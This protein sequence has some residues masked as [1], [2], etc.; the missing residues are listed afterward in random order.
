LPTWEHVLESVANWLAETLFVGKILKL[1]PTDRGLLKLWERFE[2]KQILG[3]VACAVILCSLMLVSIAKAGN[4]AYS[5]S[6]YWL[7]NPTVIDGKWTTADEWTDTGHIFMT[8]NATGKFA[9]K[10][11]FNNNYAMDFIVE[12][13]GDNTNNTGDYWQ[14]CFD[15]DNS[16]TTAPSSTCYMVQ[17]DGHRNLTLY[18]G[19]GSGWR[20]ATFVSTDF[21][22][23]ETLGTSMWGSTPHWILEFQV[24]SKTSGP[25]QT[26]APPN[27]LRVAAYDAATSQFAAWAPG[28][29]ANVPSTWGVIADYQ[30]AIPEGLSA[31]TVVGVVLLLASVVSLVG[32][33]YLRKRQP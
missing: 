17:I 15:N 28:S 4:S 20:T 10:M 21:T 2:L 19:T 11:D 31:G 6:E 26:G 16:A 7:A 33:S 3:I 24:A 18:Q 12:M 23:K 13:L 30:S 9:Y 1:N 14:I 29:S 8:G 32:F 5:M 27:G 25:V 22:W